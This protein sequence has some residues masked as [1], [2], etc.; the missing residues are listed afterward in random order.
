MDIISHR[1]GKFRLRQKILLPAVAIDATTKAFPAEAIKASP[2]D[3]IAESSIATAVNL[4]S[5]APFVSVL[6]AL[7]KRDKQK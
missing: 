7:F 4:D 3:I 2:L 1:H 5:A 6:F